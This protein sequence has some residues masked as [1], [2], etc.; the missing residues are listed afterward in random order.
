[1]KHKVVDEEARAGADGK[2]HS[3]R[4]RCSCDEVIVVEA[5]PNMTPGE[6]R[7]YAH[8]QWTAHA[9]ED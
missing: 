2:G 8:A 5:V 3:H 4:I 7:T 1:M 6:A 9:A